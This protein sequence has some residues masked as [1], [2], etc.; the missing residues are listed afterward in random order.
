MGVSR[1]PPE[2]AGARA[3]LT[4]ERERR[5]QARGVAGWRAPGHPWSGCWRRCGPLAPTIRTPKKIRQHNDFTKETRFYGAFLHVSRLNPKN[6]WYGGYA[7]GSVPGT[8]IIGQYYPV[9]LT[10]Y[11]SG[12]GTWRAGTYFNLGSQNPGDNYTWGLNR[13]PLPHDV[14]PQQYV[15]FNFTVRAPSV[16][17]SYNF[18]W[19]PVA[20]GKAWFGFASPNM[21]INVTT[22]PSGSISA[23]PSPC[24]IPYGSDRCTSTIAW[25]SNRGDAEV[26]V[27]NIDGSNPVLFGRAQSA[28]APASWITAGGFRFTLKSAGAAITHVDVY[29]V[30]AS[31][32]P[33]VDPDPPICP[34]KYCQEP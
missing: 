22:P 12:E 34:T 30:Q 32:P 5:D 16:P 13:V 28:S 23:N 10:F 18:Q 27:S 25:N 19:R 9:S 17:G 31:E 8:M 24:S 11:N 1:L 2:L 3:D 20:D 4:K 33:P 21:V 6:S 15:T 14:G 26:W 7:G 29:G